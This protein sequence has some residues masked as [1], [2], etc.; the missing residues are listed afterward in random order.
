[1][2]TARTYPFSID[3]SHK[4]FNYQTGHNLL[5][6]FFVYSSI[7]M[8]SESQ[9]TPKKLLIIFTHYLFKKKKKKRGTVVQ[10]GNQL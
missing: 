4:H 6:L 8:H 2:K 7:N 1:M 5:Y 10:C 9:S 3:K